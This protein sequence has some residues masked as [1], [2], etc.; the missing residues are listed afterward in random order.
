M[1]STGTTAAGFGGVHQL[2]LENA[3]G[4]AVEA[5]DFGVLWTNATAGATA[6]DLFFRTGTNTSLIEKLRLTSTGNL[7]IGTT[8]DAASLA[9][10][11]VVNGSGAGAT[12][13]STTTGALRVTGGA[14]FTGNIN[15]GGTVS[16][17]AGLAWGTGTGS[18]AQGQIYQ[19]SGGNNGT[20]LA[21]KTGATYDFFLS[22]PSGNPILRVP[23]GTQNATF[24]A[25]TE[26]T[27]SAGVGALTTAGGIHAAKRIVSDSTEASAGS[28]TGSGIFAGGIYA[29]AASVFG[30]G[31]STNP[32]TVNLG[33]GGNSGYV[34][35]SAPAS[36]DRGIVI[37]QMRT[38]NYD[39]AMVTKNLVAVAGADTAKTLASSAY[40]GMIYRSD[41][42][43]DWVANS[44]STAG[45]AITPTVRMSLSNAGVLSST[46]TF[47]ASSTGTSPA[48]MGTGFAGF[49]EF[50]H[51]TGFGAAG[52]YALLQ[53]STGETYL[54][55]AS[56][57][58]L[59]LRVAN[60]NALT[61]SSTTA[62]FAGT[63]IAPAATASLAPLRI[64]HGTAPTSPTNGDMWTTTAGLYIRINGATVGP[65]S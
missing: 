24:Q 12:A 6:A 58:N 38:L 15:A 39:D 53:D 11:L 27:T 7:L 51:A 44:T 52:T 63:V 30:S 47:T 60:S 36:T 56:G 4:T 35:F 22:T 29:G 3:S 31:S 2:F 41:G 5:A 17:A 46:G 14:G 9:G 48:K 13:S 64:P 57:K 50:S 23:T 32:L 16:G 28:T 40:A 20:V 1:T 49:A 8:T 25:T 62:T 43:I 10:G 61:L 59:Y 37:S 55:T 18:F 45:A 33:N 65:L 54:N 19:D 42:N 21:S 34:L 26:A